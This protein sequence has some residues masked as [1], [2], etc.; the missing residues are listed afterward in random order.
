MCDK[1]RVFK[2][3][4]EIVSWFDN[5]R[6]KDLSLEQPYLAYAKEHLPRYAKILDLGCGTGEPIA[7]F[8]S[9]Y[10]YSLVGI[11]ASE[12]MIQLC[13]KRFP[14]HCWIINDMRELQINETFDLVLAWHSLFHLPHDDQ[15]QIL[16]HIGSYVSP[17]GLLMFTSGHE[18]G[19][20]WSNNG[21]YDLY[22]ASLSIEEYKK[23]LQENG[24]NIEMNKIQDPNRPS[25]SRS[26]V[27]KLNFSGATE[28]I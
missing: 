26:A 19:E 6:T 17:G 28:R 20:V 23:I 10:G 5:A 16:K 14:K 24:F 22:H 12:K 7:K 18:H 21:G 13:R 1:N 11:D 3:Y 9:D 15:R 8:F 4:D 25:R 27:K 2:A